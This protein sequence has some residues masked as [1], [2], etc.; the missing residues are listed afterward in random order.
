MLNLTSHPVSRASVGRA[1]LTPS[2]V[3]CAVAATAGFQTR[4]YNR[5]FSTTVVMMHSSK[6]AQR[7]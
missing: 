1:P 3:V 6:E 7:H 2:F 4:V 5:R